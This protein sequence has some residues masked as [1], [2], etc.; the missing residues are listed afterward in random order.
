MTVAVGVAVAVT[1]G[2]TVA[3]TVGVGVGLAVGVGIAS[4]GSR[5]PPPDGWLAGGA[6]DD[7]GTLARTAFMY[8]D[9]I[10]A[11]RVPPVTWATPW[12]PSI[13]LLASR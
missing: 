12:M 8:V 11:G 3:V 2:V 4:S 9:H 7:G 13:A 10:V 1:V 5:K 6:N